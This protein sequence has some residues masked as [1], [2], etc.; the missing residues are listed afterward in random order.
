MINNLINNKDIKSSDLMLALEGI[1]DGFCIHCNNIN[2]LSKQLALDAKKLSDK[3]FEKEYHFSKRDYFSDDFKL[4]PN[5]S[6]YRLGE[7]VA[8][9]LGLTKEQIL[10]GGYKYTTFGYE[11]AKL[12]I[13]DSDFLGGEYVP[14]YDFIH[15]PNI[16]FKNKEM[17]RSVT[18]FSGDEFYI[19]SAA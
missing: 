4:I 10:S 14:E 16:D 3:A 1:H 13:K 19:V 18:I 6:T 17:K 11:I 8:K 2:R 15:F 5:L 12:F 7:F 9:L